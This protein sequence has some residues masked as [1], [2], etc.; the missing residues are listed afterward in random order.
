MCLGLP[1]TGIPQSKVVRL[2]GKILQAAL[3]EAHHLVAACIRSDEVGHAL[4]EVD[5]LLLIVGEAEK[6][7]FL[8][9]PFDR[10]AGGRQALAVARS[11]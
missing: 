7:A 10:R 4:I 3:D 1:G 5:Q 9:H 8:L 11:A 2:I 6:I